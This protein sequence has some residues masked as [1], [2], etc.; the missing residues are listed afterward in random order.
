MK[1]T[2]T[3]LADGR[4]LIYYDRRDDA[5]RTAVDQRHLPDP[6]PPSQLR[7][8]PLL[9]EV[10]AIAAHRQTRT[11]QPGTGECPLC[12]SKPGK[13]TE[14]PASDY[15]VAVFEN[16]FPAF[17]HRAGEGDEVANAG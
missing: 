8:D 6:P 10:V 7:R 5:D 11:F 12:P 16:R 1:R 13:H 17:S 15:E 9:D 14:I 3:H 2:Y 4:L